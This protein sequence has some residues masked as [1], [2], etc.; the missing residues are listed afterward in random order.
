MKTQLVF[1]ATLLLGLQM[2]AQQLTRPEQITIKGSYT[3]PIVSPNGNYALLTKE[4]YSGVFLLNLK[5]KQVLQLSDKEGSGYAYSWNPDSKT[6]YFKE[7]E[8]KEYFSNSKVVRYEIGSKKRTMLKDVNHNYLPSYGKTNNGIV[9]Y[10]N[11]T[12]LKIEAKDLKTSKSW[13]I[14]TEE[15]QYYN[16]LLSNDGTKVAVHNGADIFVYTVDGKSKGVKV[17]TG[18]ATSWSQDNNYLI[19]FMDESKD[20]HSVTN[21][22]LYLFDVIALKSIK[23]TATENTFEMFPC[24]YGTNKVMFSDEKTGKIYTSELKL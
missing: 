6:I 21:S 17:G 3:N 9:I 5:N 18:I 13:V 23:I 20:G 24:F 15:G 22:D 11:P 14:T 8:A 2:Q 1:A 19:G 7:K 12:T 16:A 4:H 10:T